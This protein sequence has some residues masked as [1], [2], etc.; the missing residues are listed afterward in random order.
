MLHAILNGAW[1][2][3]EEWLLR[4]VESGRLLPEGPF[5]HGAFPGSRK[6][7]LLQ[8]GGRPVQPLAGVAAHV[9]VRDAEERQRLEALVEAA[10]ARL[11]GTR[12]GCSVCIL[13]GMGTGAKPAS[14]GAPRPRRGLAQCAFVDERW[15][16][17][18]I[19][20]CEAQDPSSEKYSLQ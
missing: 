10:G 13:G 16:Y 15:L 2:L 20:C 4:S 5:E 8:E 12:R 6:A 3:H 18:S 19:S 1:L 14:M 17:D 7:R 9:S 11:C